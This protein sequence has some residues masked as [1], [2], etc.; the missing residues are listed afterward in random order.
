MATAAE[1][2]LLLENF[3]TGHGL[4]VMTHNQFIMVKQFI[5]NN[6]FIVSTNFLASNSLK[7]S[8]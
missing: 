5:R 2:K 6:D 7:A 8:C 4:K 1:E 3:F